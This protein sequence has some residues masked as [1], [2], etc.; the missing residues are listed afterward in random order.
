M[1][2]STPGVMSTF[3]G[4]YVTSKTKGE[5]S[6]L[7]HH[8]QSILAAAAMICISIRSLVLHLCKSRLWEKW[9]SSLAMSDT[10][11]LSLCYFCSSSLETPEN[12]EVKVLP[13]QVLSSTQKITWL[14]PTL[15][16]EWNSYVALSGSSAYTHTPCRCCLPIL[17]RAV[18]WASCGLLLFSKSLLRKRALDLS[19]L[20][21]LFNW[22]IIEI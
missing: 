20:F 18:S 11:N 15:C 17:Y 9:S 21:Y 13:F 7:G 16:W 1:A 5:A 3:W 14:C 4:A 12:G 2:S 8:R 6:C 19:V 10:Y 22:D